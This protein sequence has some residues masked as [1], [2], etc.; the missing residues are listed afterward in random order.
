MNTAKAMRHIMCCSIVLVGLISTA[1]AHG[2]GVH[3]FGTVMDM[4][5]NTLTVT[6]QDHTTM[7]IILT[8]KTHFTPVGTG[9]TTEKPQVGDRVVIEATQ[10]NERLTAH[11]IRFSTVSVKKP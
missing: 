7:S 10:S 2:K 11:D 4:V 5:G 1:W 9:T 6:T 3:V 8:P